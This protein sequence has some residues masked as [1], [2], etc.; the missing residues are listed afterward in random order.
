MQ[1]DFLKCYLIKTL[2]QCLSL[3]SRSDRFDMAVFNKQILDAC[4]NAGNSVTHPGNVFIKQ[5]D[6]FGLIWSHQCNFFLSC[7]WYELL[8]N[9][10]NCGLWGY[11]DLD[12]G[13]LKSA[14][15]GDQVDVCAKFKE[16]PSRHSWNIPFTR[17]GRTERHRQPE[18]LK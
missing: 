2:C 9:E 10:Q 3:I 4:D 13:P 12:L 15:H 18:K 16:I 11:S 1:H 7:L 5:V 14:H 8:S 17:M 6:I